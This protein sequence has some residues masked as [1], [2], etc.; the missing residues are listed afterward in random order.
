MEVIVTLNLK[1]AASSAC[2]GGNSKSTDLQLDPKSN[3]QAVV[4]VLHAAFPDA[5]TTI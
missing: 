3:D 5:S 1:M 4:V 2:S